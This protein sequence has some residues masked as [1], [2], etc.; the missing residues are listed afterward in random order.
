[1]LS[2]YRDPE[3]GRKEG[4][5]EGGD[6]GGDGAGA[7]RELRGG[8]DAPGR[9]AGGAAQGAHPDD[10]REGSRDQR[11]APRGPRQAAYGV[12]P[13]RGE[14][15]LYYLLVVLS[16]SSGFNVCWTR[17]RSRGTADA[18]VPVTSSMGGNSDVI[19]SPRPW[20]RSQRALA[21]FF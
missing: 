6:G 8:A 17:T 7:A 15:L 2:C 11:R 10:R 5:K 18:H 19:P 12:L 21:L 1:V 3:E 13:P 20:A 14:L 4:R 9:V 16:D